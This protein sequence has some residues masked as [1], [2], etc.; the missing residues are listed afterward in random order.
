MFTVRGQFDVRVDAKGR[1]Q[2]PARLREQ[3]AAHG[4][5]Q[6]VLAAWDGGLQRFNR[7]SRDFL[8]AYVASATDVEVDNQGRIRVPPSLRKRAAL[9]K[10]AVLVSFLGELE[11]WSA[12]RWAARHEAAVAAVEDEG[13]FDDLLPLQE[14]GL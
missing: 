13:A 1:L 6:L 3:L 11:I 9:E 4:V 2:L 14:A 7:R 12:E 5:A 10:D 8:L